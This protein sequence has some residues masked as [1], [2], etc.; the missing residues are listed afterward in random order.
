MGISAPVYL[1]VVVTGL[2]C[3]VLRLHSRGEL[4]TVTTGGDGPDNSSTSV[5]VQALEEPSSQGLYLALLLVVGGALSLCCCC[6]LCTCGSE[7]ART[8]S[9]PHKKGKRLVRDVGS[10]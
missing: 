1:Y 9:I 2:T 8:E 5:E 4:Q 10:G 3:E 6:C 7:P